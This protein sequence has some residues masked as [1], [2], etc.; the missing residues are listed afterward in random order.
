MA[1]CIGAGTQRASYHQQACSDM[2]VE[3]LEMTEVQAK[4]YA[5]ALESLRSAA[6]SSGLQPGALHSACAMAP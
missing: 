6:C 1:A 3:H 5:E 2:Q 4:L